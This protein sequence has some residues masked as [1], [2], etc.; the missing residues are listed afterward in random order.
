MVKQDACDTDY[1]GG[2][3]NLYAIMLGESEVAYIETAIYKVS[4]GVKQSRLSHRPHCLI[5][6]NRLS[7]QSSSEIREIIKEI[8]EFVLLISM[9]Q[10]L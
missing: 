8:S 9:Y 10:C 1:A 7:H 2:V 6:N 5:I 3:C 4:N